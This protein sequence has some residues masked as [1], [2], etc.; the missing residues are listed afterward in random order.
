MRRVDHVDCLYVVGIRTLTWQ[1]SRLQPL[2]EMLESGRAR[3]EPASVVR[4]LSSVS[5]VSAKVR[6]LLTIG[7][8]AVKTAHTSARYAIKLLQMKQ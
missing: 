7:D 6:N 1:L 4:W 2:R 8:A 3:S 5:F